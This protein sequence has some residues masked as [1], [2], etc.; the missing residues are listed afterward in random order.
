MN[1]TRIEKARCYT[2]NPPPSFLLLGSL[3]AAGVV[4]EHADLPAEAGLE[5][6]DGFLEDRG[7]LASTVI[8]MA[9]LSSFSHYIIST[10]NPD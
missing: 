1:K 10:Y 3:T 9:R 8:S 6:W 2:P 5:G 7:T 4:R